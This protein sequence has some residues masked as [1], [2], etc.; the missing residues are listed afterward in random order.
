MLHIYS[1]PY[2]FYSN[3]YPYNENTFTIDIQDFIKNTTSSQL[4]NIDY[5]IKYLIQS[6]SES[7]LLKQRLDNQQDIYMYYY[8]KKDTFE[9]LNEVY[10]RFKTDHSYYS[11]DFLPKLLSISSYIKNFEK[12]L[13]TKFSLCYLHTS[14]NKYIYTNFDVEHNTLFQ[15][16]FMMQR[17]KD[18][19]E[20][21]ESTITELS[22]YSEN[23]KYIDIMYFCKLIQESD[24]KM[25]VIEYIH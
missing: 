20:A 18:T 23:I 14:D 10:N 25:K 5:I 3:E 6:Y 4:D 16:S 9:G 7:F 11:S 2:L 12:A 24:Y 17:S 1:S 13:Y 21:I 15:N 22:F 8:I 19:K